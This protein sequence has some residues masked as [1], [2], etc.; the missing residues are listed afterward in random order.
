MKSN[1]LFA[2]AFWLIAAAAAGELTIVSQDAGGLDLIFQPGP[3]RLLT[4]ADPA[5]GVHPHFADAATV[6]DPG[7]PWLPGRS[8]MIALPSQRP[9]RVRVLGAETELLPGV[10]V[11]PV[12][13]AQDWQ[14]RDEA[15]AAAAEF[16]WAKVGEPASQRGLAVATLH[17][18][19]ARLRPE[20][21]ERVHKLRLRVDFESAP[22]RRPTP[23]RAG[24]WTQLRAGSILNW[25]SARAFAT[26]SPPL[27]GFVQSGSLPID[28]SDNWLRL[29]IDHSAV[30]A[31]SANDFSAAGVDAGSVDPASLRVFA[32]P[33]T[34]LPES[35]AVDPQV[36]VEI[37]ALLNHDGD[38]LFEGEE[39][40]FFYGAAL[41]A[42]LDEDEAYGRPHPYAD[43]NAYWLSWGGSDEPL[44]ALAEDARPQGGEISQSSVRRLVHRE[45]E[46]LSSYSWGVDWYW[47]LQI[48]PGQVTHRY[49]FDL[50]QAAPQGSAWIGVREIGKNTIS[51]INPEHH[52]E[53]F[54]NDPGNLVA[55]AEWDG[56]TEQI[57]A[58]VPAL[59][60]A[61]G[62]NEVLV[63][64]VRDR[65]AGSF[66]DQLL[67]DWIAVEYDASLAAGGRDQWDFHLEREAG[68]SAASLAIGGLSGPP[69]W[70]WEVNDP[71]APQLLSG[72]VQGSEEVIRVSRT[73][74]LAYHAA[75]AAEA[76]LA[77]QRHLPVHLRDHPGGADWIAIT[78]A[79][80]L[81]EA[82]RLAAHRRS[83]GLRTAVVD[84][85]DIYAEFSCGVPDPTALRDF[86]HAAYVGWQAPAPS[87]VLL[88]GD[89][90]FDMKNNSGYAEH[91]HVLPTYQTPAR[92]YTSSVDA[93]D[94][95]FAEVDGQDDVQ[96][97][98]LGRI[99]VVS[100]TEAREA[101]DKILRYESDEDRD[102]W[103]LRT[104]LVA[105]DER[106]PDYEFYGET[107]HT[108]DS[109]RL[110]DQA[111]PNW[112]E[113]E[114][115]YL[116]DYELNGREKPDARD[117]II[118]SFNRGAL[119][120]N[121]LGHGNQVQWAHENV[122]LSTRDVPLL[123]NER[124]WPLVLAGSCTVGRFD[125][126]NQD[127]MA[128]DLTRPY[129]RG[130][131]AMVAATRPTYSNPNFRM[132]RSLMQLLLVEGERSA[133]LDLGGAHLGAR[134]AEGNT[135]NDKLNHLF[136]D[137]AMQLA[138]PRHE[139]QID[140]LNVAIEPLA[141][142]NVQGRVT[143]AAGRLLASGG[144]VHLVVR[145]SGFDDVYTIPSPVQRLH[146]KRRG[147]VL[148]RG[149]AALHGGEFSASFIAPRGFRGG[150]RGELIA[151]ADLGDAG[152]AS[153][154]RADLP[155]AAE[156]LRLDAVQALHP[157]DA[158]DNAPLFV[159][160]AGPDSIESRYPLQGF[161][162]RPWGWPAEG[163]DDPDLAMGAPDQ[164]GTAIEP[165]AWLGI[166]FDDGPQE[167]PISDGAGDGSGPDLRIHQLEDASAAVFA[168]ADAIQWRYL[169]VV[170]RAGEDLDLSGILSKARYLRVFPTATDTS[171]IDPNPPDIRVF[172][173]GRELAPSGTSVN[174]GTSFNFVLQDEQGIALLPG[175]DRGLA[176]SVEALSASGAV[177][178]REDFDL[179]G[180][181]HYD[182]GSHQRGRVT[183]TL[184]EPPGRYRLTLSAS[185]NTGARASSAVEISV[186]AG[187]SLSHVRAY[188]SPF[189]ER[190]WITWRGTVPGTATV[191]I[192][193]TTGKLIR[194]LEGAVDSSLEGYGMVEWKGRDQDGDRVANGVYL[195]RV[196]LQSTES[197]DQADGLGRVV[198]MR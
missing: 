197:K 183:H 112:L 106:N 134:L 87:Y 22:P 28:Q 141:T 77:I 85:A 184:D 175:I 98:M 110:A 169:G 155:Y 68:Q 143:D 157:I 182:Q 74:R 109:E 6:G 168:S 156:A 81:P 136:G 73:G 57:I 52:V 167:T 4:S 103:R 16:P 64:V 193:T 99:S 177:I 116:V 71:L 21:L 196:E 31:V 148:F 131:I 125:L 19:A 33:P 15:Y 178:D 124:R 159:A 188:P 61:A 154:I 26:A 17:L 94:G 114:R 152:D 48:G 128:E 38:A 176:L 160:R 89:G 138:R 2:L 149:R 186:G 144:S 45:E 198:V 44:R 194:V 75:A 34:P 102:E 32:R 51:N 39:Q 79:E 14:R 8:C 63:S 120:V 27:R 121:Y 96:D 163:I 127:C 60:P 97:L 107:V 82:E 83:R 118:A 101:V 62:A 66:S 7:A 11:A 135:R 25:E 13:N 29:D 95:W 91:R 172:A 47:E 126:A 84:I 165:G 146:F 55:A 161:A 162:E 171:G 46:H 185:D 41:R 54:L 129:D 150:S 158:N 76:P 187:F 195:V 86:L 115:L 36:F 174:R 180:A 137:P 30:Y 65:D 108:Y 20:G 179:G 78:S 93:L 69:R 92:R 59:G 9:A 113:V 42:A 50:P 70:I 105:D 133:G 142:I 72:D 80:L 164:A 37:P 119:L 140:S 111:V 100:S 139:V 151:Y 122:F 5:G 49:D 56:L 3:L 181:F 170:H 173:A 88:F 43:R 145:E 10:D 191:K 166:D 189:A 132:M 58:G 23:A 35:L 192:Y 40:I 12:P 117:A 147:D 104:V 123:N 53:V 130:A 24:P 190:T 1:G 153:G 18:Q 67:L 90:S